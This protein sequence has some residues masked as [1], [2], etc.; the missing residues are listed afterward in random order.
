MCVS[1]CVLMNLYAVK[2]TCACNIHL[3]KVCLVFP[4]AWWIYVWEW[5]LNEH[6]MWALRSQIW[7]FSVGDGIAKTLC[8]NFLPNFHGVFGFREVEER[9]FLNYILFGSKKLEGIGGKM[10]GIKSLPSHAHLPS[11]LGGILIGEEVLHNFWTVRIILSWY[12]IYLSSP[13][14]SI[15]TVYYLYFPSPFP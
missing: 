2:E 15:S 14:C 12:F 9:G 13:P 5:I 6:I 3:I 1:G 7:V 11:N 8:C 4:C 10:W